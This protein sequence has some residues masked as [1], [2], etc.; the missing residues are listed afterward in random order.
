M[1]QDAIADSRVGKSV[2]LIEPAP[3]GARIAADFFG[4]WFKVEIIGKKVGLGHFALPIFM[5]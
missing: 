1:D 5:G 3:H 4:E 2:G